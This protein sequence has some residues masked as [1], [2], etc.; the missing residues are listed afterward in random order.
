MKL[1]I[2]GAGKYGKEIED[3]AEH[4]NKHTSIQFLGDRLENKLVDFAQLFSPKRW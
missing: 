2:L 1:V 4:T 3:V